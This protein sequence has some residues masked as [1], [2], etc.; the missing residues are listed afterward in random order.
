[1]S[2]WSDGGWIDEG[3]GGDGSHRQTSV[4]PWC[5]S[6]SHP[7]LLL[8]RNITVATKGAGKYFENTLP[9][10]HETLKCV[11]SC[12][13]ALCCF[14]LFC[15]RFYWKSLLRVYHA[16][17]AISNEGRGVQNKPFFASIWSK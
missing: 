3:G 7:V 8:P 13:K 15:L 17:I 5:F 10:S 1:M 16:A 2:A 11:F 14:S 12:E 4:E 6:L 9:S